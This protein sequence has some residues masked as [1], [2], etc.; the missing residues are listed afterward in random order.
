LKLVVPS[1]ISSATSP[2]EDR[3]VESERRNGARDGREARR[4]S[5]VFLLLSS[6]TPVFDA[7]ARMR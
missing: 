1:G 5:F 2:V 7:C 6:R 3:A 4:Q